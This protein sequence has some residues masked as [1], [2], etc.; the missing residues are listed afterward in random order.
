MEQHQS[1]SAPTRQFNLG[2]RTVLGF[3]GSSVAID[4]ARWLLKRMGARIIDL[5]ADDFDVDMPVIVVGQPGAKAKAAQGRRRTPLLVRL[6]DFHVDTAGS[7]VQASAVSGVSWAIGL[8]GKAPL[9][10]SAHIPE[11][12]CGTLGAS[13]ALSYYVERATLPGHDAG[14]RVFDVST[15]EILRAFADQNFGNHKQIPTS[16]RRNGRVSPEHGGIFPQGFFR[17]QDGYVAVIGRSRQDWA[18]ILSALGDPAWATEE[19][20]NPFKLA[21]DSAAVEALFEGELQKYTRDQ[22][23]NLALEFGA[24]FAPILAKSEIPAGKLVRDSFFDADGLPGLPFE[25]HA[26]Q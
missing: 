14:P 6:W 3:A 17:C 26:D 13:A 25:I 4:Y 20:R 2:E 11:K 7:G 1:G 23:L 22:L 12:W 15:A 16:W 24:T 21:M 19:L 5:D 9:Y 10:L 8:P 18:L